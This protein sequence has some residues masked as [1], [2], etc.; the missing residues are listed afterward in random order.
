MVVTSR[1]LLAYSA[2]IGE[3]SE[4]FYNDASP[5]FGASPFFCVAPEW[6]FILSSRH[7]GLGL[8][9]FEARRGVHA[10]QSTQFLAVLRP[11]HRIRVTGSIVSVRQTRAGALTETEMKIDD[12]TDGVPI[13]STSSQ[14]IYRDVAVEGGDRFPDR[15]HLPNSES[16]SLA[17]GSECVIPLDRWYA[18]RYSE[19]AAIWNPIHTEQSVAHAAGLPGTIVHGT[20]LWALSGKAIAAAYAQG[21]TRGLTALSGR[22]TAMVRSGTSVKLRYA[23]SA[24]DPRQIRFELLNEHGAAAI[25]HG[26]ARLAW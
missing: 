12:L 15:A 6:Q 4:H 16:A 26:I 13:S 11:G 5:D 22:F 21:D 2:A 7:A 23:P 19:C 3:E 25:S 14:A 9:A 8:D 24:D 18:H 10:S 17:G 1:M 20:A